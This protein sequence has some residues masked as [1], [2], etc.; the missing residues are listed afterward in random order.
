MGGGGGDGGRENNKNT[1]ICDVTLP[2]K[3]YS[4]GVASLVPGWIRLGLPL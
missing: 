4:V 3:V 2:P 1:N